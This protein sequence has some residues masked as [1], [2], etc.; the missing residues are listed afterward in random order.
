MFANFIYFIVALLILSLYE[1]PAQ[2]P[3]TLGQALT[4]FMGLAALYAIYVRSRFQR[5]LSQVDWETPARLDHLFTLLNTRCAIVSL[6]LLAVDIWWLHMPAYLRPVPWFDVLPTLNSL[7]FLLVFVGYLTIM[8][9]FSYDAH[10]VIYRTNISRG[11]YVYSNISFSVPVLIPWV[12]LFG[13]TDMIQLLPFELLKR[14]LDDPVGQIV[15]FLVF[16]VVTAIFAPLLIQRFWRCR[17]MEAG[18]DRGRIEALCRR[19][20]VHYADI[21]Y[22]PIFGGRMITAAVMGLVARFRYILVTDALLKMLSPAEVDQVIAHEIGHVKRKHLL[23]YLLFFIGFMVISY[24]AYP[25]SALLFFKGPILE[26]LSFFHLDPFTL[27]NFATAIILLVSIV[28]YFRFVFGYFMR[29]FERQADVYVFE[30]FPTAR[31]LI[32]TF[33]KIVLSSGQPADKPNWHH[34]SI[35]QRVD[36]L[37]RCEHHPEWIIRQNQKVSKSIVVFVAAFMLLALGAFQLNQMVLHSGSR[38]I[39]VTELEAYLDQKENKTVE[40]G[41][42]YW[43]I[44]NVYY[45]QQNL[46]RAA[47]AY[48]AAIVLDPKNSDAFNNLAWLLATSDNP[49]LRDPQ[50]ALQY[51]QKAILLHKA[52]HIWDTLAEC[53][54]ANGRVAEAIEA[55]KKALL[56]APEDR[57]IYENQMEKFKKALGPAQK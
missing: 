35:K 13:I 54:Y 42:R 46:E 11:N 16:L 10:K 14:I 51:A 4:A 36:Y 1:P 45:E 48:E 3:L 19:A 32:S 24:A 21:V 6:V 38:Y 12:L 27:R 34:F 25:V 39:S 22:W 53:L 17:S 2:L 55:E 15:Y 49:S 44:G 56:M 40:D 26:L 5:L 30:L 7:L 29:N 52:P 31:P 37:W 8:W 18:P 9:V 33:D 57:Q 28:V 20:G 41:V 50:K 43:I 47:S 23:L